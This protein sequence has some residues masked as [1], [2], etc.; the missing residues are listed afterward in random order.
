VQSLRV[1]LSA[2]FNEFGALYLLAPVGFVF[3]PASLRR[4]TIVAAPIALV[5]CYVQ[6]PDRALWNFHFLVAP[7]AALTL[8]RAPLALAGLTVAAFAVANLRVGA[9]LMAVPAARYAL[10]LSVVF[11]IVAIAPVLA[12]AVR[13]PVKTA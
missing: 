4:L 3:A 7:L 13:S 6:Q 1:V 10:A 11:A 5:L 2:M 12:Q 9:Q 8:E